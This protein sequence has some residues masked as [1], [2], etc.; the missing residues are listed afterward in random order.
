MKSLREIVVIPS[1]DTAL[2]ST[3]TWLKHL[4][5]TNT[6]GTAATVTVKDSTGNILRINGLCLLMAEL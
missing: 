4:F 6:T 1:T 5:V 3:D 2:S